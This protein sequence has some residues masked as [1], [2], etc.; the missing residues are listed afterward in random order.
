M[1]TGDL[2]PGHADLP[3]KLPTKCRSGFVSILGRPN[4]GK[5][6]LLNAF[7]GS[8]VAIVTEKPQTTRTALQG[9]VTLDG[10]GA[11]CKV[12][13]GESPEKETAPAAQIIFLD[14][15]GIQQPR[16]SLDEQM[17]EEVRDALGDRD[18]LL[19][20][21]D[22]SRPFGPPDEYALGF[23]KR[24]N[25]PCFLVFNK[26]D[27]IGKEALLPLIEQCR[28][29]HV[30]AEVI[31]ISALTGENLPLLLERIVAHLPEGPLYFPPEHI[32]DLPLRFLAGEIIREKVILETRQE[33]PYAS[34]VLVEKF[35]EK[36]NLTHIAAEIFVEREGQKGI[37][38]GAG[39][40]MLKRIGTLAR[41][42][43][44]G[45]L[46]K[47]V[48]LELHVKVRERWRNDPEFLKE[49]DW[50]RMVGE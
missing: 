37:V 33:L 39:G 23:V 25:V 16:T 43:L 50:R 11:P 14:T 30:F 49:L 46:E 17:M 34:A 31:P 12:F 28:Q 26:I 32:T 47:K 2:L 9:V 5:S 19:F 45:L 48:F 35:E 18:L 10:Q 42:E 40:Q 13:P 6:T 21:V 29:L 22:A 24:A 20:L 38:I 8:K 15:P 1:D 7:V 36:E 4:A 41:Q 44:E 27:R 3:Q